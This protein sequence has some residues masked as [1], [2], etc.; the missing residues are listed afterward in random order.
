MPK[1]IPPAVYPYGPKYDPNVSCAFHVCYIR[2][3]IEDYGLFKNRAQEL[4]DHKILS[5][6]EEGPN[7]RTDGGEYSH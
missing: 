1:G 4:I 5:F 2:H 7:V 6:S 3:S